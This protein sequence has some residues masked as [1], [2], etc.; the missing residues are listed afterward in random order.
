MSHGLHCPLSCICRPTIEHV[1]TFL[2]FLDSGEF[3]ICQSLLVKEWHVVAALLYTMINSPDKIDM[4]NWPFSRIQ[5]H[6]SLHIDGGDKWLM[7]LAHFAVIA[8]DWKLLVEIVSTDHSAINFKCEMTKHGSRYQRETL[9]YFITRNTPEPIVRLLASKEVDRTRYSKIE[10]SV[11]F[12]TMHEWAYEPVGVR[13]DL[14]RFYLRGRK[15]SINVTRLLSFLPDVIQCLVPA[16]Y[17]RGGFGQW[18]DLGI[19]DRSSQ[20]DSQPPHE[21][22]STICVQ[23]ESNLAANS[24]PTCGICMDAKSNST[25]GCGHAQYCHACLSKMEFCPTCRTPG[26]AL[27][28]YF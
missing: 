7:S 25:M 10:T 20:T 24:I 15:R 11:P 22:T 6:K 13:L 5:N 4:I 23:T 27:Q 2:K 28:L 17:V 16:R 26:E 12:I 3:A 8:E 9:A 14:A 21:S 18:T 1:Q 19:S